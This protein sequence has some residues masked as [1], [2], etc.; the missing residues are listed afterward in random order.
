M[1]RVQT[2]RVDV[3]RHQLQAQDIMGVRRSSGAGPPPLPFM[4]EKHEG[5][6]STSRRET[7][8]TMMTTTTSLSVCAPVIVIDRTVQHNELTIDWDQYT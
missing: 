4:K 1:I 8:P 6:W 2:S 7:S 5:N 3:L